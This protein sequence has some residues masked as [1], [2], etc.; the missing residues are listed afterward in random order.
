MDTPTTE[1]WAA[2]EVAADT[3]TPAPKGIPEEAIAAKI[4]VGLDRDQAIAVLV[5]QAAIDAISA[6]VAKPKAK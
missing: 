6:K 2:S 4:E 1:D 5:A 3:P